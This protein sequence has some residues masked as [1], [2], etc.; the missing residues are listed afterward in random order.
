MVAVFFHRCPPVRGTPSLT[1]CPV[2]ASALEGTSSGQLEEVQDGRGGACEEDTSQ[3]SKWGRRGQKVPSCRREGPLPYDPGTPPPPSFPSPF[4]F[5]S[6]LLLFPKYLS[7]YESHTYLADHPGYKRILH[8][9]ILASLSLGRLHALLE[10][11]AAF[12]MQAES[13]Q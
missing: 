6:S 2:G 11:A 3:I 12:W 8:L 13:S 4:A 10:E 5:L 9:N 7:C 1:A